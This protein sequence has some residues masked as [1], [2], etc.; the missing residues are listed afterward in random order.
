MWAFLIMAVL[1]LTGVAFT[2][3]SLGFIL[4]AIGNAEWRRAW[5]YATALVGLGLLKMSIIPGGLAKWLVEIPFMLIGLPLFLAWLGIPFLLACHDIWNWL[6]TRPRPT[7]KRWGIRCTG[8][9]LFFCMLLA[10]DFV[11]V[12]VFSQFQ[13]QFQHLLKEAPAHRDFS[14]SVNQ[15][16]GPYRVDHYC[17]DDRGGV[18][19]RTNTGHDGLGPDTVSYGFAFRP[20]QKGSPYGN[21][22]YSH[23]H[24]F[25]DWYTFSASND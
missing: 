23:F 13:D 3:L 12:L 15:K 5:F 14:Y 11:T 20:N 25:G 4:V 19:F 10:S 21:T 16:I 1:L 6:F 7:G 9:V 17:A 8:L 22:A 2:I 24:L 18:F